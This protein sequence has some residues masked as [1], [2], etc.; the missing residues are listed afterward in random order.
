MEGENHRLLETEKKWRHSFKKA[1][2]YRRES[3]TGD[4]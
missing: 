1:K 2:K 3:G 4:T